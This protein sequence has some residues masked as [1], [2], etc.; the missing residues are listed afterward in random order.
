MLARLLHG[1]VDIIPLAV[2]LGD[3]VRWLAVVVSFTV[4]R[5]GN[6]AFQDTVNL[7]GIALIEASG[8]FWRHAGFDGEVVIEPRIA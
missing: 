8:S 3:L 1:V 6:P 5:V 2:E 7:A 4:V